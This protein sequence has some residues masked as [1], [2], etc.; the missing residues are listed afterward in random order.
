M[1]L[2]FQDVLEAIRLQAMV[3]SLVFAEQ[4]QDG[5][6]S[7]EGLNAA[8]HL[9]RDVTVKVWGKLNILNVRTMNRHA[10]VAHYQ[11]T[12]D[13]FGGLTNCN[14]ARKETKHGSLRKANKNSNNHFPEVSMLEK[15]NVRY[16]VLFT[17]LVFLFG[18]CFKRSF[19]WQGSGTVRD[20][21]LLP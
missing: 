12:H 11:E 17:C 6:G 15:E 21:W 2:P 7:G 5:P 19:W 9:C 20:G 18:F 1:F 8:L 3:N 13:D 4:H 14:A 16:V 10:P